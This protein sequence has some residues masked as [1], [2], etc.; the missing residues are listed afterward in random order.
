MPMRKQWMLLTLSVLAVLATP[1]ILSWT[2]SSAYAGNALTAADTDADGTLDKA[3]V[4]K[5]A[6][7]TFDK[8]DTDKDGQLDKAEVGKRLSKVSFAAADPDHDGQLSKDE[9]TAAADRYFAAAD[10]DHDGAVDAKEL[11]TKPGRALDRLIN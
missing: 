9:Y 1:A 11:K 8:L 2:I 5:A 7:A 10:T 3:E 4:D 6:A